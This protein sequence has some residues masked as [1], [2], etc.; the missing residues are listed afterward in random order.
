M[1]TIYS[2]NNLIIKNLL[3][4]TNKDNYFLIE[5]VHLIDEALKN[6]L[7]KEIF[8]VE[9]FLSIYKNFPNI[10]LVNDKVIKKLSSVEEPQ[11]IIALCEKK[12]VHKSN[13]NKILILD[14]IQDPGNL[15][16]IIRSAAAFN[17][18]KIIA[19]PNSVSLYN[20]K[21]LRST[22]GL[23]MKVEYETEN[24]DLTFKK[25][26]LQ[27]YHIFSTFLNEKDNL[28]IIDLINK[29]D[30]NKQIALVIGSEAKGIN[31]KYAK[32]IDTNLKLNT[33]SVESLNLAVAGSILMYILNNKFN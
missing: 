32:Y 11:G 19:S 4:L 27:K 7:V 1:K 5:G 29:I 10:C 24:L 12:Q 15:G 25:L 30:N 8:L 33:N 2:T 31:L 21:V 22:Q 16:T 3:K 17:F 26:K 23:F 13:N 18:D 14:S 6:N 20:Q 28:E 9:K